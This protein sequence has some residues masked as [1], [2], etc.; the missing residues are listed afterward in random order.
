MASLTFL[1]WQDY[2]NVCR[3]FLWNAFVEGK[4]ETREQQTQVL[5]LMDGSNVSA[6]VPYGRGVTMRTVRKE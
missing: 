5:R 2:D 6:G 4:R 3:M 1:I